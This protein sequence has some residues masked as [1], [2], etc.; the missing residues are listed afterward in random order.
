VGA[1]QIAP[2]AVLPIVPYSDTACQRVLDKL[3]FS[4]PKKLK[5]PETHRVARASQKNIHEW[6]V[7]DQA[8][9]VDPYL[10]LSE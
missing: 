3:R 7:T 8:H 2:T 10:N 4:A 9:K 6:V 1:H 5:F